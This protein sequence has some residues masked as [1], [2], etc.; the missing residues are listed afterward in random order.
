MSDPTR[1]PRP[2]PGT[3]IPGAGDRCHCRHRRDDHEG[4]CTAVALGDDHELVTCPCAGFV[5]AAGPL[6][7]DWVDITDHV[8]EASTHPGHLD[9]RCP[10]WESELPAGARLERLQVVDVQPDDL[11]VGTLDRKSVV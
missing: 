2:T 10:E 3:V 4:P 11:I 8:I 9:G 6:P 1:N 7:G 5:L